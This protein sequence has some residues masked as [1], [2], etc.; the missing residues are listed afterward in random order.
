MDHNSSGRSGGPFQ[1]GW[2]GI[3]LVRR[4]RLQSIGA[5]AMMKETPQCMMESR[6]MDFLVF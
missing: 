4:W 6:A 1:G 2:F 5:F 3:V